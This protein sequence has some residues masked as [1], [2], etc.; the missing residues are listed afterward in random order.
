MRKYFWPILVIMLALLVA[1]TWVLFPQAI[2]SVRST[3]SSCA[4]AARDG[5]A[6]LWAK[7]EESAPEVPPD[8]SGAIPPDLTAPVTAGPGENTGNLPAGKVGTVRGTR[9]EALDRFLDYIQNAG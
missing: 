7:S 8:T 5:W 3:I 9:T 1:G 6:R 4:A 2:T